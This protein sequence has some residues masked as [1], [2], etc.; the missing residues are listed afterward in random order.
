[1]ILHILVLILVP[2]ADRLTQLH[3]ELLKL[4]LEGIDIIVLKQVFVLHLA[5]L[6]HLFNLEVLLLRVR[7]LR[8]DLLDDRNVNVF[9]LVLSFHLSIVHEGRS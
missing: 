9:I 3:L 5:L 2:E 4:L 1:M 6:L 7:P 8:T